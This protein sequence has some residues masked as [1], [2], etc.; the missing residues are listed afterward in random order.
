ML[1]RYPYWGWLLLSLVLWCINGYYFHLHKKAITPEQMAQT[2]NK[3]LGHR[4]EM[5]RD[6][7]KEQDLILRIYTDSVSEKEFNRIKSLPFSIY[8]Y[9]NDSLKFWN[10]NSA[11]AGIND[12]ALSKEVI[13]SNEKGVYIEK[14]I[15][16]IY[17]DSNKTLVILFP[18]LI[19][20]PLENNYLKSHFAAS[21]N[22]PVKTKIIPTST[23][24][25]VGYPISVDGKQ[26]IFFLQ[27]NMQDIQKWTPDKLF[28]SFLI[29]AVLAS[30]WWLQ[31]MTIYFTRKRSALTGFVVT[32]ATIFTLRSLLYVFGFPFNLDT[33]PFFSSDLYASSIYL[34]SLGD[35]FID[36]ICLLWLVIFITRHTPYQNY[37]GPNIRKGLRYFIALFLIV[38]L[39]AYVYLFVN[40][41]RSLVLDSS[42]SFDVSHFYSINIYT[43]LGILVI[44]TITGIS[45]LI[46][47]LFNIQLN[48]LISNKAVKYILVA[49]TGVMLI[50]ITGINHDH[51]MRI[52]PFDWL[53][54]WILLIWLLIFIPL[55]DIRNFTLVSDL[56]EPHMIFWAVFI[57]LFSTLVL[58][59]FNQTKEQ[60]TRIAYVKLHLTPKRDDVVE[61]AFDNT[62]RKVQLDKTLKAF[63]NNPSAASR[64]AINQYF[65]P[66]YFTGAALNQY[67]S[68]LYLFDA[69]GKGLFNKDTA[70]DFAS[71]LNEKNESGSTNSSYLFYRENIHDRHYYL[72]WIPVYGDNINR[73]IG[74]AIIDLDLKKQAT[75]T[76]YPE[77][78]QPVT[79]SVNTRDNEY[80]YAL[81]I[82]DKVYSQTNDYPFATYLKNDTLK[83]EQDYAFYTKN[84]VS[85]L[86]YKISDKSTIVIV[87]IHSQIIEMITLFSYLFV[88]EVLLAVIILSYQL[89]LSYFSGNF[90]SEKFV[91]LTLR[92]R[93][94]FSMLGV[95]L[96]SFIII[97][98]V[99]IV[100]FSI[101]YQ[102]SNADN[103]QSAMQLA[104]QSIQDNLKQQKAF[105]NDYVFDSVS[106][107]NGFKTFISTLASGQKIDINIFNRKGV[108][109][110]TS[111]DDIYN[112]GLISHMMRP[113]AYYQ[114]TDIGKSIV[115]QDEKV[116]GL[117][118]LSAYQ[119]LRDE[120]GIIHGFINVPF[121]T[122]QKELNFQISNIVVTLINLYAFIFLFSSL[123]TVFITRWI[124]KS[125]NVI[126]QQFGRINLQKNERIVWAYDDEIG[127]LVSEYN[128]MVN[129]VEENA[130]M[131][132]Q[133]ERESAWREMARQVAHEIKNPLTPMKLNIQY[134]QQ[135][136]RNDIPNI[137]ELTDRVSYSII[138]QIDNLSY[139]ASGFS[140]FAKMPEA[141]PEELELGVLLNKAV[142]LYL[143]DENI[144][145][146]IA[147]NPEKIY[148]LSDRSQL[149]RVFTNLLE[150]AKQAIPANKAGNIK[151][152]VTTE[153]N[154][155]I[156]TITDNG[157]GIPED[158]VSK[159]FQPYFTTKSSGTGLGLAMTKKIIEFWK[160][161][162]WFK[163][164]ASEGTVF[165]I[166]LPLIK[167]PTA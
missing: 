161:E 159:L 4:E 153:G 63:F 119:P 90:S 54:Y 167:Y 156:I 25:T 74:Y 27:F 34:S 150:N 19:T 154:D 79:N 91:R 64:K 31:L 148:V 23:H 56:F 7:I 116:A 96:I 149:L 110:N 26:P 60:L 155:A 75:Q 125:F 28:I 68:K 37:F 53:F 112:K 43:V 16:P 101:Q 10:T 131:L 152:S 47:Y 39:M 6:F 133:S 2:V 111:D 146:S 109:L 166:K 65:D 94:H 118:Y 22:I 72:S 103:Y 57:C 130:A 8:A 127:L 67:E 137:K 11:I 143:N 136:M 102:A 129:K 33:L 92:R 123:I 70:V 29:A 115:I 132:A 121:F 88:I 85:E 45:C 71:L 44:G 128:K 141:R 126:I 15:K 9:E 106:R 134:L 36:T 69:K 55:L 93:V 77:L 145:F 113:D 59:Y 108:L 138:E 139:I 62:A 105:E 5:Y 20:Y 1:R 18:V 100:F 89:Y 32:L 50:S 58:Q 51:D 42:I 157:H 160:G 38:L 107:S 87:H 82:N 46:V 66:L 73:V 114:L 83:K 86:Y 13:I 48:T 84:N 49:V 81:Y 80:A 95:V 124:T 12:T 35:L 140:N 41:I 40:I 78:L 163:T 30:I 122:S 151:V 120:H 24:P 104:R 52:V 144:N 98:F 97:G 158:V 147:E 76:V 142:E 99:T 14:C 61:Y 164:T 117:S 17:Y 21:Y 162:I 135:A 165:Y 3:D